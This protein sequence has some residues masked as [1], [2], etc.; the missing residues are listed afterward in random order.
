MVGMHAPLPLRVR[1]SRPE[2]GEDLAAALAAGDCH[3]ARVAG[4]T[5]VVLHR[6]ASHDDE[7]RV[8]LQFCLRAWAGRHTGGRAELV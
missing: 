4:D 6:A 8:E 7:A 2:L 5:F 3:C 1:I